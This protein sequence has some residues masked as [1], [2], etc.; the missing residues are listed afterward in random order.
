VKSDDLKDAVE[1]ESME[2]AFPRWQMFLKQYDEWVTANKERLDREAQE[3]DP[4][5]YPGRRR[6]GEDYRE[7]MVRTCKFKKNISIKLQCC[8][9]TPGKCCNL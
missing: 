6:L 9:S 1:D 2:G 7:G 8:G 3:V 4:E 5:Y